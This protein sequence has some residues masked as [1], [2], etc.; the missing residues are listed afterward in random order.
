M[1]YNLLFVLVFI[2]EWNV[3]VDLMRRGLKFF[4]FLSNIKIFLNGFK[5]VKF[6]FFY[7]ILRFY[8]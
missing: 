5:G 6:F 2:V 4:F 1:Y 8:Y 3:R 7:V